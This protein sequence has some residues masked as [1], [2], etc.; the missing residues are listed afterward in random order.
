M[1]QGQLYQIFRAIR[2]RQTRSKFELNSTD[3]EGR[4]DFNDWGEL[5]EKYLEDIKGNSRNRLS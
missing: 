3:I 2:Q 1:K 4:R 5:V